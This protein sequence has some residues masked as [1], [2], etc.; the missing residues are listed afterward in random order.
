MIALHQFLY[1]VSLYKAL[2][3]DNLIVVI[4]AYPYFAF[5]SSLIPTPPLKANTS[6]I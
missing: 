5:Y 1:H 3:D 2:N 4:V 6:L